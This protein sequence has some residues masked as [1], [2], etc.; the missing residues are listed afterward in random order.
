MLTYLIRLFLSDRP[1]VYTTTAQ[2]LHEHTALA[3]PMICGSG[4]AHIH[5]VLKLE[6]EGCKALQL[7]FVFWFS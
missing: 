2:R 3:G 5:L 1:C 4:L 7:I 6:G